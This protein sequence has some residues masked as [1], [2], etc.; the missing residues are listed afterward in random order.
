[1]SFKLVS[2]QKIS[3]QSGFVVQGGDRYTL[4]YVE[5]SKILVIPVEDRVEDNYE[6]YW[7]KATRWE[8]PFQDD[9]ITTD[10]LNRIKSNV[11]SALKFE[12]I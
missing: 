7:N 3:H 6:I 11:L 4:E 10:E 2:P 1:M 9:S 12:K 5:G 8:P